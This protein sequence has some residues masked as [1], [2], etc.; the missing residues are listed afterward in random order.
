MVVVLLVEVVDRQRKLEELEQEIQNLRSS[1][2][3][4]PDPYA[5]SRLFEGTDL[6]VN[7]FSGSQ[8]TSVLSPQISAMTNELPPAIPA[9]S[10]AEKSETPIQT[11]SS[12]SS[13]SIDAVTLDGSQIDQCF[14]LFF[15]RYH[16]YIPFLNPKLSP[17]DY[18]SRS[19]LLFWVIIYV[20]SRRSPNDP[21]LE[22]RLIPSVK[23][24]LWECISNPPHTWELV[25]AIVLV[26]MWPFPTSSLSTDNTVILVTTAQTMAMRLGLH[27]PDAI[28]DFSRTNRR[29]SQEETTESLKTWAACFIAIQNVVFTDGLPLV[30]SDHMIDRICDNRTPGLVPERLRVQLVMSRF[31]A[32]VCSVMAGS[33][34]FPANGKSSGENLSLLALLE[35]DFIDMSA[36]ISDK[37]TPETSIMLDGSRLHLYVFFLL[38]SSGSDVRRR[39]LL[40]AFNTA[41]T[42]IAKMR[43]LDTTHGTLEY[44]H[45][46]MFRSLALAAS[47]ILKIGYSS[48]AQYLDFETGKHSFYTATQLMRRT[49]MEDNDLPGR[50]SKIM[51]QLWSAQARIDRSS[52]EPSLKLKTRLSG[53]LLHDFL[54][55]WRE[56]FGGQGDGA[57]DAQTGAL[58]SSENVVNDDNQ[59]FHFPSEIGD[60]ML[61]F[62][63]MLDSE[64]LSLLPFTFEGNMSVDQ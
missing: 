21:G 31:V 11:L 62:E 16:P 8:G 13:R 55:S 38:E 41:T 28:R 35:Q 32:R 12:A 27:R 45:F 34:K 20:S 51:T 52:E 9:I 57:V 14:H 19:P 48:Y 56:T 50:M 17:E 30:S 2:A 58:G 59:T 26:C 39:A 61:Q 10:F 24:L 22:V 29:L 46:V 42:L 18:Y 37:L 15:G 1:M 25:Q 63:Y 53:S 44:G 23:R 43:D 33:A 47:F 3:T 49:S 54:W 36:A 7:D 4:A 40:R 60:D 6:P 64:F 5:N